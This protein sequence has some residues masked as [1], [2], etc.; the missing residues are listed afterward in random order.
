MEQDIKGDFISF[1]TVFITYHVTLFHI[2]SYHTVLIMCM[3]SAFQS[4]LLKMFWERS[5]SISCIPCRGSSRSFSVLNQL[6]KGINSAKTN[7]DSEDEF[8]SRHL[9]T[10][11]VE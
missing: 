7:F 6:V 4:D 1:I 5:R 3:D 10:V 9:L 2:I 11:R 8:E